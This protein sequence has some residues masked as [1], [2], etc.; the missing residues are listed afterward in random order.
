MAPDAVQKAG[1]DKIK[2]SK[3][4]GFESIEKRYRDW[5]GGRRGTGKR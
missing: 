5:D 2:H 4:I 1:E 3:S